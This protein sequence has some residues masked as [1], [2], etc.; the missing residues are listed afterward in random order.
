M[1]EEL[2]AYIVRLAQYTRNHPQAD[3]GASPR[4]AIALMKAAKSRAL[5]RGR[6][7]VLPDDI[8]ALAP[9]VLAH[10]IILSPEAELNGYTGHDVVSQ[11]IENTRY[12]RT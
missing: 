3:L 2:F 8:R 9:L 10:R 12:G 1:D 6:D 4:A 7:Y 11:A 5:L